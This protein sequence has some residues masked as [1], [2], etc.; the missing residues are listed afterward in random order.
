MSGPCQ[1]RL[2]FDLVTTL[3]GSGLTLLVSAAALRYGEQVRWTLPELYAGVG[4]GLL[5]LGLL[6]GLVYVAA[7]WR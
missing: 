7:G 1:S 2:G 4:A 3:V 5:G 6:V